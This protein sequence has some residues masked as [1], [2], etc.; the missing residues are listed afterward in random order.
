MY[1]KIARKNVRKSLKDY[2]IYFLTLTF[3]VCLFY[4]F[5]SINDQ[6]VMYEM[7]QSTKEY[8]KLMQNLI[9]GVSV[10][11]SVILGGLIIYATNFL[12][13]RRKK[14]FGVY[15][16][17]GMSKG[18]ISVILF[19][20]TLLIGIVSLVAGLA[21]GFVASQGL[22]IFAAKL[23]AVDMT[24]YK[25]I[26]SSS[27][28]SKTIIYFGIMYLIVM[29]F[30]VVIISKYKLIDLL[31]ASKKSEKIKVRNPYIA[32]FIFA[33][34]VIMLGIAYYLVIKVGLNFFDKRFAVCIILGILGTIFFYYGVSSIVFIL[35]QKNKNHYLNELN[36][37]ITRQI[38]SKFK[39]NFLSMSI[40]CLMLFIT[41][42]IMC[43]GL[44]V[45]TALESS[46]KRYSP[47]DATIQI[48]KLDKDSK[49]IDAKDILKALNYDF[50]NNTDY[51]IMYGY[52]LPVS[53]KELLSKYADESI[54][55]MMGS[56]VWNSTMAITES[57]YNG[58]LRLQ[59]KK[60]IKLDE[61]EI[62]VANNMET[63]T[64]I[65]KS[66]LN[67]NDYIELAGK[68]YYF[69]DKKIIEDSFA[70]TGFANT[71][72][73]LIVPDKVVEGIEGQ[74]PVVNLN[75][76]SENKE[77]VIN[78]I[79]D[80]DQKINFRDRGYNVVSTTKTSVYEQNM[81]ISAIILFVAMYIGIIFLLASAAILAIQQ[82]SQCNESVE[83]YNSLIKI[84]ATKGQINKS[85][86]VQVITFF[87]LPLSLSIIHSIVGII[88]IKDYMTLFGD[89]NIVKTAIFT[90][91]IMII[92]YGGYFYSTYIGYKNIVNNE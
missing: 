1:S 30:N 5:N 28:I 53:S 70:T 3:A 81:G 26:I 27:A 19:L 67:D 37:F 32:S 66:F 25:F 12:I 86:F 92:V 78:E 89:F 45:K 68:K 23:F 87:A 36:V 55:G 31:S 44:G 62:L 43:G 50:E 35:I 69:K 14:E 48:I 29:V 21:I 34:S 75:V 18:K 88:V 57:S 77:E 15:M 38:S 7:N 82:L 4:S 33:L 8:V 74:S 49:T 13:N 84:G 24:D 51:E 64:P 63:M 54:K 52:Y 83:R 73:T 20:E 76:T 85:I 90:A 47:Y 42:G 46:I 72:F 22:S 60:E 65:V 9:S 58:L 80:L 10:F 16:T 61:N 59:G 41:I 11:V 2:T 40:I 17:L 71:I 56:E 91:I 39:T 6:S 79:Y